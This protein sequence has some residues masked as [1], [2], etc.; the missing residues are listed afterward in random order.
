MMPSEHTGATGSGSDDPAARPT[1]TGASGGA[2]P[3]GTGRRARLV[4]AELTRDQGSNAVIRVELERGG[5]HRAAERRAIGDE[6]VLLRSAA[7]ATLDALSDLL[8][9]FGPFE[10]VGVKRILAF[11]AAVIL[12]CVRAPAD[13]P[14]KL[15]GCVPADESGIGAAAR[16]VLHATNRLA[17]AMPEE[18][19]PPSSGAERESETAVD[20]DEG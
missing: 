20:R 4:S 11:D 15:L 19:P 2:G 14:G 12:A 18:P 1:S 16:A 13:P 6:M 5:R 7:L 3:R 8:G 9:E 17:E 10:L